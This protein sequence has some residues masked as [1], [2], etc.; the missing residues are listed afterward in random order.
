MSERLTNLDELDEHEFTNCML[1]R[2]WY[3]TF[4]PVTFQEINASYWRIHDD[5]DKDATIADLRARLA[6]A[7]KQ[8]DALLA[9]LKNTTFWL[10]QNPVDKRVDWD[11]WDGAIRWAQSAIALCDAKEVTHDQN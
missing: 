8:R 9:A 3:S 5:T 2:T 1:V 7:E 10:T 4:E 6:A 11:S